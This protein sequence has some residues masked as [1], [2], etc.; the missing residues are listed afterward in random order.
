MR[1]ILFIVIGFFSLSAFRYHYH[2]SVKAIFSDSKN[3]GIFIPDA[4]KTDLRKPA[5]L[6]KGRKVVL[7]YYFNNEYKKDERGRLVRFH[8]T[9]EDEANTG[10]SFFG[11]TFQQSGAIIESLKTA[12]TR[13]SLRDADIYIIVDPDTKKETADPHFISPRDARVIY[14]WV[15]SGGVLLL[16]G[17]DSANAEFLHFNQLAEK[18]G[19]HF[20]EDRR[21]HVTGNH[22]ETG[23]FSFK[24]GDSI[25]RT[26][27]K[28]FMKDISTLHVESPAKAYLSEGADVIIAISHVGKGTVFA[29]GDPWFYNE[30]VEGKNLPAEYENAHAA[31]DLAKWLLL[32]SKKAPF[33]TEN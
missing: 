19:I 3:T 29:V 30:Y 11:N 27:K 24:D 25:F 32:Q 15:K 31:K 23:A 9:W 1:D 7:D 17:N 21:N 13:S 6:G 16:M 12:P 5:A 14:H 33:S 20:N 18:F 2:S 8:Y 26:T 22:F 10:F 4:G 28:I